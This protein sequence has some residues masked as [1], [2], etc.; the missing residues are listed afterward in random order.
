MLCEIKE[1]TNT[2]WFWEQRTNSREE[3]DFILYDKAF[4]L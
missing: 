1:I 3:L 4:C 2:E